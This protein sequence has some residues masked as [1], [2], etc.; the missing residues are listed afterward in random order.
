[1]FSPDG[2]LIR[3]FVGDDYSALHDIEIRQEGDDEFIYGARN[4]AAMGIKFHAVTGDVVLRLPFGDLCTK[5]CQK[6]DFLKRCE[7]LA[8][9]EVW[10]R[11]G[12]P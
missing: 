12:S 2:K 6:T 9:T 3:R 7:K 1:M 11:G 4:N 10:T 5:R 8:K